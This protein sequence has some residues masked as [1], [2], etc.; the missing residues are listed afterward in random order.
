MVPLDAPKVEHQCSS[1]HPGSESTNDT[2][3][4]KWYRDL[5]THCLDTKEHVF[6]DLPSS[7]S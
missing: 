5:G 2:T 6:N 4:S 1:D 7:A 3:L